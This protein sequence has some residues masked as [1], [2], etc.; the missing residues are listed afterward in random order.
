MLQN[1]FEQYRLGF[2]TPGQ[3]TARNAISQFETLVENHQVIKYRPTATHA[4]VR[5][6]ITSL[7]VDSHSGGRHLLSGGDDGGVSLWGVDESSTS[8][9]TLRCKR[10]RVSRRD[11]RHNAVVPR[12]ARTTD[13]TRLVHSF[14]T[15]ANKFRMYRGS[16][17]AAVPP[18]EAD[19]Q[20]AHQF[21]VTSVKWYGSDNGM[22]F[23]GG[24]DRTV[25]IWDTNTFECVQDLALGYVVNQLDCTNNSLNSVLVASDDYYPRMIDLRNMNMGVTIFGKGSQRGVPMKHEILTCKMDPARE[26]IVA[27]GD[28][29]G[30]VKVWDLRQ[31]NNLLVQ[32]SRGG[33]SAHRAS[34]VDICWNHEGTKLASVSLDGTIVLW[35]PF[36]N[37]R[38]VNNFSDRENMNPFAESEHPH[39][40]QL[41]ETDRTRVRHA[42]RTSQRLQWVAG[43]YLAVNTD[44]G[45]LQVYDTVQGKYWN[46]IEF[47]HD[48]GATV[49]RAGQFTGLAITEDMTNGIGLRLFAGATQRAR[50]PQGIAPAASYLV[51]I[52]P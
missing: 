27:S 18:G 3:F 6:T 19:A 41:G 32:L 25:K 9:G 43:K 46:K 24:N 8:G 12:G 2:L 4:H 34:C 26:Y 38:Y 30:S 21:R 28:S 7:D 15:S 40:K 5:P 52:R 42:R 20:S 16:R 35:D 36:D 37:N 39:F 50:D 49:G 45:E 47:P 11:T 29:S 14:E 33:D 1:L 48:E 51:E 44:L 13:D 17:P 22:F 23:S 10:L 31:T